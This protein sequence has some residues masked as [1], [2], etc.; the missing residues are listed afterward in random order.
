[1]ANEL[2]KLEQETRTEGPRSDPADLE[3]IKRAA[4]GRRSGVIYFVKEA[5]IL[6]RATDG[7]RLPNEVLWPT[8]WRP[9]IGQLTVSPEG[10]QGAPAPSVRGGPDNQADPIM[11]TQL[12]E[13]DLEEAQEIAAGRG[14]PLSGW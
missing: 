13:I 4:E 14:L 2:E 11:T 10:N 7:H 3:L 8:G 5:D 12:E 9:L 1:M 6:Y